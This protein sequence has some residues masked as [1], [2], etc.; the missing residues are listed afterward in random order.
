MQQFTVYLDEKVTIWSRQEFYVEAE[1]KEEALSI[2]KKK[3]KPMDR[4]TLNT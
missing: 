3:L 1:T 4:I 2:A